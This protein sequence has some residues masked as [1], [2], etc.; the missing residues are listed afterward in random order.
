MARSQDPDSAGSQFFICL[1]PAPSLDNGYTAF[2]QLVKGDEVLERI[3]NT[4]VS[5]NPFSG[6]PSVP[7]KR[8][9]VKSVKIVPG[10]EV[11]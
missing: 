11:K 9:E 3:G 7:Q 5:A 2:G 6:E 4:P 10:T 1:A 8:I